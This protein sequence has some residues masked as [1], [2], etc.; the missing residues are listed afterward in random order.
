MTESFANKRGRLTL[1]PGKHLRRVIHC[2]CHKEASGLTL[3]CKE[4]C[5][6]P[7]QSFISITGLL[8]KGLTLFWRMLPREVVESLDF[9]VPFGL[10]KAA[11]SDRFKS[12]K[13]YSVISQV[14][15]SE[16]CCTSF[17]FFGEMHPAVRSFL[18]EGG[19]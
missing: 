12:K 14:K 1:T 16:Q 6:L 2:T 5:H 13:E 3:G 15:P 8:K 18:I 17:V 9:F 19:R 11:T 4:R 10:H 7:V